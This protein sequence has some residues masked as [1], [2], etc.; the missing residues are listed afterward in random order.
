MLDSLTLRLFVEI[1]I[2]D[3]IVFEL[4]HCTSLSFEEA[5][6]FEEFTN[7]DRSYDVEYVLFFA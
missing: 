1:F 6:F 7:S 3:E 5:D 2:C 4:R